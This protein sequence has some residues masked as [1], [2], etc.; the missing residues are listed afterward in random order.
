MLKNPNL[1]PVNCMEN[2]V[3]D[4]HL[5]RRHLV[6]SLRYL[7]DATEV[8]EG[9]EVPPTYTRLAKFTRDLLG[10]SG[11]GSGESAVASGLVK[12]IEKLDAL[13]GKADIARR[14]AGSNTIAPSDQ[15]EFTR[16][17]S[18]TCNANYLE[19]NPQLGY[20]AL[21]S[22]YESLNYER[23]YLATSLCSISRLG[24]LSVEEIKH[25]V[26]L[27]STN[28]THPLLYYIL[29]AI[30]LAFDPF[31]PSSRVGSS[32]QML[33]TD[34]SLLVYMAKKFA[35]STSWKE[36]GLKATLLL[37]WTMFLT[38]TRHNDASLEHRTGFTTE[39]LETQ[40]WNAV[41]GD[42]FGYLAY[43]VVHLQRKHGSVPAASL[44]NYPPAEQEQ[45][46]TP[47]EDFKLT[48]ISTFETLVRSLITHASSE[49]RKIKQRQEDLVLASARTER[50]RIPSRFG[51]SLAPEADK[52]SATPRQDIAML[53]SF[54]GLLYAALPAERALQFWGAG[55][56]SDSHHV[57][58]LEYVESTSGR[59]PAFLQ[60]A[61]WSTS[62]QDLTMLAALYDMLSG[63]AKGQQCSELAYNF[64]ARGGEILPG[65]M[66]SSSSTGP[67]VSWT[68]IFSLLESWAASATNPR[69]QAQPQPLGI[70]QSFGS[71]QNYAASP[72]AAQQVTIGPKDVLLSQSFLRLLSTVV[73]YSV[74]VRTAISGHA[75]FR[76]IPTLISLIPLGIPLELKG[77]LFETLSA[78][79]EPGAGAPGVEICKA[80]WTLMERLEVINVRAGSTSGF[81][82]ALATSKGVELELEQIESVHRLYPATIPF[83]K[84]LSTAIH[85]SKRMPL[86]DRAAGLEPSNT[87]PESLG[88]PYRIPGIGPFTSFVIDTVFA[89]IPNREYA[90]PSD[91]W[92]TN[93]LCLCYIERALASFNLESLVTA[94][95]DVPIKGESL[96]PLLIHPGYDIM[97]RLLTNSPLQSNLLTYIIEGVGGFEKEVPVEEPF[98]LTTM[99]RVLRIVHRVLEIQDIFLDVLIPLLSD[100]NNSSTFV[101]QVNSRSYFTRFDQALSFG[102]QYAPALATY[103]TFATYSEVVL[104]SIK[105]MTF[106]S[107]S[108]FFSNLV[109]LVERSGDSDRILGGF[110]HV[111]GTESMEDVLEAEA[112]TEQITGAGAPDN[113]EISDPLKQATRLAALDLLIQDTASHRP[114]PNIAHFLLFGSVNGEYQIQDPHAL[115]A[116]RTSIH[117]LLDLVNAGVPRSKGKR[118][119]RDQE[120][121]QVEPLFKSLPALAERCYNVVYQLCVHPRTSEFTMRYLRTREDFFA[122][123]L[124]RVPSQAPLT[125]QEPPIQVIYGDGSRIITTVTSLSSFIRL[126]S[127]IFDLVA[128]ELHVLTSRNHFKGV[129]EILEILFGTD[130]EYEEEYD[131]PTFHEVGQ[132]QMRIIDFFQSL[133]FEWSDSLSVEPVTLQ[134]LAQ[135]NLQACIRKDAAGCEIVD[136]IAL[137]QLLAAANRALHAQGS[138]VT[139]A[140]GD[141][142]SRETAYILE[143]C[144]VENHRRKVS[145]SLI[146]GFEAWRRLL[147]LALTKCFD[148]LPHDHRENML[149]D[150]LHVLP[151]AIRSPHIEVSTAVLLSETVL[152]L[153]TK[154]REDRQQHLILQSTGGDTESSSLPAERLY[155]ILRNVLQGILDNNHL[156]LVRGNL[157]AA[158]INFIHLIGSSNGTQWVEAQR[159]GSSMSFSTFGRDSLISS[160]QALVPLDKVGQS[161]S[162]PSSLESGCLAVMKPTLERL[163]TAISRDAIDGTEVWKTVAFMLLDAT[164]QLSGL[165]KQHIVLSVLNRHGILS[166]FVHGIKESDTRLQSVLKPDP[167]TFCNHLICLPS[168]C[169]LQT[170]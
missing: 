26:D 124:A 30:F 14:S 52:A 127:F 142:L 84:L 60:W 146:S 35:P 66:G 32:R 24:F 49:L 71:L 132:S 70:S 152:S 82:M 86:S 118:K 88:Q 159:K 163:V 37:K 170:T 2:T 169:G 113:S 168:D 65:R 122:R 79:C 9:A 31:D 83:L 1:A 103:M 16:S 41:Q 12:E 97:K 69:G 40:V 140:H 13:I 125:L 128:L 120:N 11:S 72:P 33:A 28:P 6:D 10:D 166:N 162:Y 5:Y 161:Q 61:I 39:E 102:P 154:L 51:S 148:R 45:R 91:R 156:E 18:V 123:Q 114:Y 63:L 54:I 94:P 67:S 80:V 131:F 158:L 42:A 111:I 110:M 105:I 90:Q 139:A 29:T 130:F 116:Q 8:A 73:T 149:F 141:Q 133:T 93:D 27:L 96:V 68:V 134:F 59:L 55:P 56:S 155:N 144:A 119:E 85:T 112:V 108:T 62:V 21:N 109:A 57:T 129:L 100:F 38:E 151:A 160:S 76:A 138:I 53:Y 153:I 137:L 20:D 43:A 58:Y 98:F 7:L 92:K 3:A 143:S 99:V 87:I 95:E 164:V 47:P 147:D 34:N 145:H 4:F 23:R 50:N 22:R 121:A 48:V 46:E 78:F 36:P 150:L 165:E 157:Y 107:T 167:G 126:R 19:G 77:A 81:S 117:V 104:L 136:R 17:S 135:F 25:L 115:G 101:G 64:M 74:A 89:N 15:G 75:H 106:L 44:V